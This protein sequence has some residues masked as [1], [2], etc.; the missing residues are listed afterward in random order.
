MRYSFIA[1]TQYCVIAITAYCYYELLQCASIAIVPTVPALDT[2]YIPYYICRKKQIAAKMI[3]KLTGNEYLKRVGPM[4]AAEKQQLAKRIGEWLDKAAPMLLPKASEPLARMQSVMQLSGEWDEDV[5]TAFNDGARMLTAFMGVTDTWLPDMLYTKSAKRAI[6]LMHDILQSNAGKLMEVPKS[7]KLPKSPKFGSPEVQSNAH[8]GDRVGEKAVAPRT[9]NVAP[10]T[11]KVALKRKDIAADGNLSSPNGKAATTEAAPQAAPVTEQVKPTAVNNALKTIDPKTIVPR[12]KH[13]SQYIYLLPK[14]TQEHASHYADLMQ[15]LGTART[16]MRLL[17][18]DD[19]STDTERARWAKMAVRLDER[20]AALR[21][22]LDDEWNKVVATGRVVV[23]VLGMAHL[24]DEDGKVADPK[25]V[26]TLPVSDKKGT[27]R[28]HHKKKYDP[29]KGMTDE[30]RAKRISY[31][32]K[33]LRDPRP[34]NTPEH[35]KQWKLFA[36]ELVA[37]GGHVTKSIVR[38][39]EHYG[40]KVPK[41]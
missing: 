11:K 17:M 2:L 15:D 8:A 39:G 29:G 30:E 34:D 7:V 3:H 31:L 38:A 13:I 26:A 19:K 5:Q 10:H 16:N 4:D 32:Q 40:A 12:P 24:L 27:S 18:D 41:Q 14:D 28:S 22:E 20:I 36:K 25:P 6:L 37:L 9:N 1:I 21:R 35:K 23:D 33:W